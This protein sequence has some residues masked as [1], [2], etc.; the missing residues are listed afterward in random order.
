[1]WLEIKLRQCWFSLRKEN[2]FE[3]FGDTQSSHSEAA[4]LKLWQLEKS[5]LTEF[6]LRIQSFT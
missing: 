1:M 3:V 5:I 4:I 2:K 6:H